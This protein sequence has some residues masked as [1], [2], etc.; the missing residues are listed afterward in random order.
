MNFRHESVRAVAVQVVGLD[1]IFLGRRSQS[2]VL[3][4]EEESGKLAHGLR[5]GGRKRPSRGHTEARPRCAPRA[6]LWIDGFGSL[7]GD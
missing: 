3:V 1:A 4:E 2:A 6:A 7:L 5:V